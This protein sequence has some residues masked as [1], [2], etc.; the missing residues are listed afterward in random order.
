[1]PKLNIKE[2]KRNAIHIFN[3]KKELLDYIKKLAFRDTDKIIITRN[4][5]HKTWIMWIE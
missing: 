3:T 2:I 4:N 5:S 1:M